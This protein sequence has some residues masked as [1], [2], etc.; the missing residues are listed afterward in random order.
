MYTSFAFSPG[1]NQIRNATELKQAMEMDVIIR[2]LQQSRRSKGTHEGRNYMGLCYSMFLKTLS[3]MSSLRTLPHFGKY[4]C[5][6]FCCEFDEKTDTASY[7]CLL[8][9]KAAARK[10]VEV[11]APGQ[12][13][14]ACKTAICHFHS[15]F[16]CTYK[17]NYI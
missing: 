16:F 4:T 6:L 15:S 13:V 10:L 7:I 14:V 3:P 17:A 2:A 12:E 9:T 1:S 8:S 11:T 5:S